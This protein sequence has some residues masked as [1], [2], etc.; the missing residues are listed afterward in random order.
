M[1]RTIVTLCFL[2][3]FLA[4]MVPAIAQSKL[5]IVIIRHGEKQEKYENLNCAGLNRS[6]KLVNVLHQKIGV[7]DYI[8]VPSVGNGATTTH[9]RMFQT[10]TPFAVTYNLSINS[11]FGSGDLEKIAKDL[12]DK[13][14][15]VLFVWNHENIV[16]LAKAL[17]VKVKGLKWSDSD[18]D[19]MWTIT[20][21][22][23]NRTLETGKEGIVPMQNC[24]AY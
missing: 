22:G 4:S 23:K 9:S 1:K 20:G 17:G 19:S 13:K 14:G 12:E 7:P 15:I 5:K 16:A 21:K 10:I 24:G 18:F 2:F 8:Y 6:L 11:R 3:A